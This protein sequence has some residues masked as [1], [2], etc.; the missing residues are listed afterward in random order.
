[1]DISSR[2]TNANTRTNILATL[3]Q[4]TNLINDPNTDIILNFAGVFVNKIKNEDSVYRL[5][6]TS[7]PLSYKI[8]LTTNVHSGVT[9]INGVTD[10][11]IALTDYTDKIIL[12]YRALNIESV[13]I[14]DKDSRIVS[15]GFDLDPVKE[16]FRI[17][18]DSFY[19]ANEE[20]N[21]HVVYNHNLPGT[22]IESNFS[23]S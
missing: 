1:M 8:E 17:Y 2:F 22:A 5:P 21:I 10:I 23:S 15:T 11:H 16:H 9:L 6:K 3:N 7:A 4:N 19:Y 18:L 20:F 12:H 13:E 14:I